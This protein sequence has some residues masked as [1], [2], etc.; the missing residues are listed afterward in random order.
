VLIVEAAD[1]DVRAIA[2][3]DARA[4]R[5]DAVRVR[6]SG[7]AVDR[8]APRRLWARFQAATVD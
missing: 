2:D 3:R 6:V 7:A 1:S 4:G 8:R 5:V